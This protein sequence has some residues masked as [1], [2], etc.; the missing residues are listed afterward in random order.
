[1]DNLDEAVGKTVEG[2]SPESGTPVDRHVVPS[3]ARSRQSRQ[4]RALARPAH[5]NVRIHTF[6][7]FKIRNFRL[8][9]IASIGSSGG[10]FM[11][12]VVIGFVAYEITGSAFLTSLALGI[13]TLPMFIGGAFGGML[14]DMLDRRKLLAICF[15]YQGLLALAFGALLFLDIANTWYL[16]AFVVLMGFSWII[17]DPG[18]NALMAQSVPRTT[19][20]NAFAVMS[21]AFGVTRLASPALGGVLIG[22]DEG[23]FTGPVIALG[24]QGLLQVG[25]ALFAF[26]LK[27]EHHGA[28]PGHGAR[29]FIKDV[30]ESFRYAFKE[31]FIVGLLLLMLLPGLFVMPYV[32]GLMPVLAADVFKVGPTGLGILFSAMGAGGLLG[33]L[34]VAALG[35]AKDKGRILALA[36]ILTIGFMALLGIN[37]SFALAIPIILFLSASFM[38]LLTLIN[39]ALQSAVKD[40]MRGRIGGM[41]QV[42]W[43]ISPLGYLLS[44]LLADYLGVLTAI[45]IATAALGVLRLGVFLKYRVISHFQ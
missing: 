43:G 10:F 15:A 35:G 20:L 36:S 6:D 28:V 12:Q 16:F 5:V 19:L 7:A 14:V 26:M 31:P 32:S 33:N 38:G 1:L 21:L 40:E 3:R 11:Q 44:G 24:L 17:I 4:F 39:A 29:G 45:L 8:L 2:V 18:R 34:V 22:L 42:V 41:I 13:D 9:W 25:A 30:G 37:R 27:S 23:K